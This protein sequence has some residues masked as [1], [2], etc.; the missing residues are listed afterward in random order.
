VHCLPLLSIGTLK[1]SGGHVQKR[2][3]TLHRASCVCSRLSLIPYPSASLC[4]WLSFSACGPQATRLL[5][6]QRIGS[7]APQPRVLHT[8]ARPPR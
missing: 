8:S 2:A 5:L 7:A 6:Y 3:L 1:Q 4:R